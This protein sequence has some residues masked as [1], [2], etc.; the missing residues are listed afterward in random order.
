MKGRIAIIGGSISG[1]FAGHF[2]LR[3]G[4]DVQ[5]FE[6]ASQLE[7]RGA[8][9]TTHHA[10]FVALQKLGIR[11]GDHVGLQIDK[12]KTFAL[13]GAEI[14]SHR[15]KQVVTSWSRLYNVLLSAFPQ[16]RYHRGCSFQSCLQHDDGVTVLFSSGEREQADVLIAADGIRSGVRQLLQ[17]AVQPEYAGYVAWRGMV[18]EEVCTAAGLTDVLPYF[19]FCLPP[20]EQCLAYPVVSEDPLSGDNARYY[21]LVWYRPACAGDKLTD[22]LTDIEGHNNGVSIA[23]NR[24]RPE[25]IA[26]M[27]KASEELLS[28]QHAAVVAKIEQ[29]FIQPVYDVV[30]TTM[31]DRRVVFI[32]DAAFTARPHLGMGVT[33]AAEDAQALAEC[34][35]QNTDSD[36]A[37]QKFKAVRQPVNELVVSRSRQLG[38]YLQSQLLTD[39]DR[40]SAEQHRSP[41]AVMRETATDDFLREYYQMQ[42]AGLD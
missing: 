22:L 38:A 3:D 11:T 41:E 1:L 32:G 39:D 4:W 7:G 10:L 19:T 30:S 40:R 17:P 15:F 28:P 8:G 12:R 34:F 27:R 25:V 20:G 21:N 33:K 18:S 5:I 6:S 31:V 9:I 14:G 36:S 29:P 42:S 26:E 23:P 24:I 13:D 37:L 35:S 2:L 16:D